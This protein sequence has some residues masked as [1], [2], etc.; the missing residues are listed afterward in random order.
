MGAGRRGLWVGSSSGE[1]FTGPDQPI[2]KRWLWGLCRPASKRRPFQSAGG[3]LACIPEPSIWTKTAMGATAT[4]RS[5]EPANRLSDARRRFCRFPPSCPPTCSCLAGSTTPLPPYHFLL[6]RKMEG[7]E[8]HCP[9]VVHAGGG[10]GT[11]QLACVCLRRSRCPSKRDLLRV[12]GG[13]GWD[14]FLN[15]EWCASVLP[16]SQCLRVDGAALLWTRMNKFLWY[17]DCQF[18][19]LNHGFNAA[20]LNPSKLASGDHFPNR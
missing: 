7:V 9:R 19:T 8:G 18:S 12:G 5:L 15:L 10:R 2:N 16:R 3:C 4:L 14:G 20:G 6:R 1:A 11:E 17:R 13:G